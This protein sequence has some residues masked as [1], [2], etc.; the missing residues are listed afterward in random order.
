MIIN[1]VDMFSSIGLA[2]HNLKAQVPS[3]IPTHN[4]FIP[5]SYLKSQDYLERISQWTDEN[6]M[7]LNIDKSNANMDKSNTNSQPASHT[8]EARLIP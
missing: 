4:Q 6:K 3:N 1:K 7:E 8:M 5:G 2:S